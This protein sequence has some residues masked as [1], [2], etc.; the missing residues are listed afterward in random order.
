MGRQLPCAA[1]CRCRP[2]ACIAQ[3]AFIARVPHCF[4][5][6]STR[7]V[8]SMLAV[9]S[10]TPEVW[11]DGERERERETWYF[12]PSQ[13]QR[14]TSGLK[15]TSICLLFTLHTSH[16]TTTFQKPQN[17]CWHKFT[18]NKTY[19]NIKHTKKIQNCCAVRRCWADT[20]RHMNRMTVSYVGA[21]SP[22][23]QKRAEWFQYFF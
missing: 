19:T 10:I 21:L 6:Y 14:I 2:W 4:S 17:Q 20:I 5:P 13:P 8:A 16:Q 11:M 22:V 12:E 3:D 23:N 9:E 7:L 15:Q 1:C 18:W